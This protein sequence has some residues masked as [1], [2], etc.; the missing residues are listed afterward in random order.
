[1]KILILIWYFLRSL[2]LRGPIGHFRILLTE[3]YYENTFKI[4]TIAFK[5]SSSSDFFHYQGAS[6]WI[7]FKVLKSITSHTLKFD[8]IDIGCGKGRALCIAEYLGYNQ[9]YGIEM[10]QELISMAQ[11]NLG[12]YS[13]KRKVS[14]FHLFCEN[15]LV[16]P[17]KNKPSV[18]FLFNPFN[19]E[20]M[21]QVLN[22]I[23]TNTQAITY[24]VY[25]NPMYDKPFKDKN[26][27]LYKV[28]KTGLYTEAKIFKL[29]PIL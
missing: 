4:K 29:E 28:C 10:D 15:A 8:F 11:T 6:Y 19:E 21:T 22:R 17:Y 24:F 14:E 5:K 23:L 18:Y 7:V 20:I 26:I 2:F 13:F 3:F 25:L 9:L 27:P 12:L 1:M 16:Y